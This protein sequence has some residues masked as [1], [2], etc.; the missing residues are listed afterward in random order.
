MAACVQTA[1]TPDA[2]AATLQS[3]GFRRSGTSRGGATFEA[4]YA[5]AAIDPDTRTGGAGQCT[6]TPRSSTFAATA[7]EL[8][9]AMQSSGLPATKLPGEEAWVLGSTGAVVLVSRSGGAMTRSQ[10]GVFRG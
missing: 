1:S 7:T 2:A 4:P 10:P 9:A 8:N 3:L 6:V 5:T